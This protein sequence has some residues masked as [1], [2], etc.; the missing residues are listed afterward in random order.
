MPTSEPQEKKKE[1]NVGA[2]AAG[3]VAGVLAILAIYLAFCSWLYRRQLKMY[4]NHVAMA[5]RT[6]F[7]ASPDPGWS[8]SASGS[9]FHISFTSL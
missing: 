6:S 1:T 3:S 2:I 5:Q 8:G 7:N 4:K 9:K